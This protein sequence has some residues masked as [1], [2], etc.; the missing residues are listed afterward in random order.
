ML[1]IALNEAFALRAQGQLVRAREEVACAG[2]LVLRLADRL[3]PEL[4]ALDRLGWLARRVPRVEP[5][6]TE[7]FRGATGHRAA[8]WNEVTHW[9]LPVARVRFLLKLRAATRAIGWLSS[10]FQHLAQDVADGVCVDPEETW[11][12]LEV[13]HYDLSTLLSEMVVVLKSCLCV[14]S[15]E[16]FRALQVRFLQAPASGVALQ[17]RPGLSRVST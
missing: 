17:P 13:L 7:H 6:H 16:S 1:S 8:A 12:T 9:L 11:N 4:K 10:E 2:Q 14:A 3:A 15:A 5:L